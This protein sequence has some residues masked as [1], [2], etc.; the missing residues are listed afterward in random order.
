MTKCEREQKRQI[1]A[2]TSSADSER[3][4]EHDVKMTCTS[5]TP[6]SGSWGLVHANP[7]WANT[8]RFMNCLYE[9]ALTETPH[10]FFTS[11]FLQSKLLPP[12]LSSLALVSRAPCTSLDRARAR[13]DVWM[14]ISSLRG[15]KSRLFAFPQSQDIRHKA[16]L[17]CSAIN[18]L[19]TPFHDFLQA[20]NSRQ[21]LVLR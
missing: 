17:C 12:T 3:Q 2:R 21:T 6:A 8:I 4:Q 1:A 5:E 14:R 15:R 16:Q 20:R 11:F 9:D 10:D 7:C 13:K 19:S 18:L